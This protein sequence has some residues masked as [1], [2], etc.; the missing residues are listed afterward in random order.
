MFSHLEFDVVE[1]PVPPV[2]EEVGVAVAV[3][4]GVVD[5]VRD[6]LPVGHGL[7]VARGHRGLLLGVELV[8]L[9]ALKKDRFM[10]CP[11]LVRDSFYLEEI[12]L[13]VAAPDEGRIHVVGDAL[14]ALGDLE[15]K[16]SISPKVQ[17][18]FFKNV[19]L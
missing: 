16:Y 10:K 14:E 4:Q 12:N 19:L 5:A 9:G 15:R 7:G 2:L 18:V 13:L 1:P 17:G 11:L 8:V 3:P 6:A